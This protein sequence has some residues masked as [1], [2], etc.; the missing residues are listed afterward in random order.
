MNNLNTQFPH[1]EDTKPTY[2][3]KDLRGDPRIL[4]K[5]AQRMP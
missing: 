3:K 5:L 2:I 4:G 1:Q